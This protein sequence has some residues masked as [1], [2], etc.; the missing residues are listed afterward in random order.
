MSSTRSNAT[1]SVFSHTHTFH[2]FLVVCS[3]KRG[4]I[5]RENHKQSL[6]RQKELEEELEQAKAKFELLVK[7]NAAKEKEIRGEK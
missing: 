3:E 1:S 4:R 5:L 7:N 6:I 2:S